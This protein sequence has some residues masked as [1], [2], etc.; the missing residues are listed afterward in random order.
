MSL[1]EVTQGKDYK[2]TPRIVR[3]TPKLAEEILT[4]NTLNRPL[5]S[6]RV[7]K[8]AADMKAGNWTLNGETIKLTADGQLLDG[9][10]RLYAV[11]FAETVVDMLLIE[12]LDASVMPT[13][14]TGA[15]R[16][17]ADVLSIRGGKN[18]LVVATTMRWLAWYKDKKRIGAPSSI[19]LSHTELLKLAEKNPDVPDRASEVMS[20]KARR[21]VPAGIVCFVYTMGHA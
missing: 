6:G 16:G 17:F 3:M 12:G 1:R 2:P 19:A 11:V 13:I 10:H 21:F 20:S 9:Q 18:N 8:Y 15:P 4:K 14:D 5:R 7:E